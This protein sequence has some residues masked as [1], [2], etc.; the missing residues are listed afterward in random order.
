M[1]NMPLRE[2]RK[3]GQSYFRNLGIVRKGRK[4]AS[5]IEYIVKRAYEALPKNLKKYIENPK[6]AITVIS[7][8]IIYEGDR[9]EVEPYKAL[10]Q[11]ASYQKKK[12]GDNTKQFLYT[13]FRL[14]EPSI[15]SHY[16][17]YMYRLGF[18]ARNY[19]MDN[20]VIEQDGS[21]VRAICE[22]P[23]KVGVSYNN[24]ELTYDFSGVDF[25]AYMS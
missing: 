24:L 19:F 7:R 11:A 15:Y 1:K 23:T 14:E 17:T 3:K 4:R 2:I 5:T 21:I 13:R 18:S 12:S 6:Q 8:M 9:L 16:N 20:V 10:K 25:S 22:L